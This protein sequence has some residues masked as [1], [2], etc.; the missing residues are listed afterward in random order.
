MTWIE[1]ASG[2]L[3]VEPKSVKIHCMHRTMH[4]PAIH[5]TQNVHSAV[6]EKRNWK[7]KHG[8]DRMLST[9]KRMVSNTLMRLVCF[10][11]V[12]HTIHVVMGPAV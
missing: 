4:R 8:G 7:H 11:V 5:L 12:F 1:N 9:E 6:V 3:W 10:E 2:V